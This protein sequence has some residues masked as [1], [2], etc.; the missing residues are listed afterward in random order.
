[1]SLLVTFPLMLWLHVGISLALRQVSVIVLAALAAL[2]LVSYIKRKQQ[3]C[4]QN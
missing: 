1:M 4:Q 3:A 2:M